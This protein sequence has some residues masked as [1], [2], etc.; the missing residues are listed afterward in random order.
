MAATRRGAASPEKVS[1]A[2][3]RG[4]MNASTAVRVSRTR[5][6]GSFVEGM[7]GEEIVTRKGVGCQVRLSSGERVEMAAGNPA[8]DGVGQQPGQ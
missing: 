7:A 5:C 3:S 2:S 8:G 1:E 4:A 6:S